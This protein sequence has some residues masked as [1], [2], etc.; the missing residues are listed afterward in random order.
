MGPLHGTPPR[1]ARPPRHRPGVRL[2]GPLWDPSMGPLHEKH[3]LLAIAPA[4]A[5]RDPYGTPPWDPSTRSAPSSPSPRRTPHGTPMGPL[6]GTPPREARPPRHRPGVRLT[7]P[8][9]DPSMGPL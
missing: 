6:H 8:L 1:E 7:G 4:Y 2:T 9:W 3:A 5:S